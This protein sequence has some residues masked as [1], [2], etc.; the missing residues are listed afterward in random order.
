MSVK[1]KFKCVYLKKKAHC[2]ALVA[3]NRFPTCF[4]QGLFARCNL[5]HRI[6]WHYYAE[7]KETSEISEFERSCVR[8][9]L[10]SFSLQ[11]ITTHTCFTNVDSTFL[12]EEADQSKQG[13][14]VF[15][16][17]YRLLSNGIFFETAL[18]EGRVMPPLLPPPQALLGF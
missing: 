6:L 11:S 4:Y 10:N 15:Q 14:L 12:S 13:K 8:A 9:K 5:Y 1:L 18:V 2:F 16:S 3:L 7:I 17:Y